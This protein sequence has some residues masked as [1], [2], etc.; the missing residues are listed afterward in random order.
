M[1]DFPTEL[2][3]YRL[4][5]H[6]RDEMKRRQIPV[7]LLEMVVNRPQQVIFEREGRKAY[8]SQL[9]FGSGKIRLLRLIVDDRFDPIIVIT[10]YRTS[11]INKY[12]RQL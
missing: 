3:K 2:M 9:D 5:A 7:E 11:K 1:D 10:L 4:T 12:W 6:A 8:Q